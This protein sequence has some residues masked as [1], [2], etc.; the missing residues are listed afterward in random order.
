MLLSLQAGFA[1]I[2][3]ETP[4]QKIVFSSQ[5]RNGRVGLL[6]ERRQDVTWSNSHNFSGF[7]VSV[8]V[9]AELRVSNRQS[10]VKP[11]SVWFADDRTLKGWNAA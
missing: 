9:A 5:E 11:E 3:I 6:F 8:T 2:R 4:L 10:E 7:G 1:K